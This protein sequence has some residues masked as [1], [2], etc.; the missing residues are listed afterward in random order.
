[1]EDRNGYKIKFYDELFV[2]LEF[3]RFKGMCMVVVLRYYNVFFFRKLFYF[4]ECIRWVYDLIWL[5]GV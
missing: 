5:F 3:L 1:M 2:I 4:V